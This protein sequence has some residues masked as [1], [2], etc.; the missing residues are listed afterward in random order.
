MKLAYGGL[1]PVLA[2]QARKIASFW[3]E[4]D[5][6]GITFS[7]DNGYLRSNMINGYPR[8]VYEEKLRLYNMYKYLKEEEQ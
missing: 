2:R 8:N 1:T 7:E 6:Y 3:A 5:Q 4:H